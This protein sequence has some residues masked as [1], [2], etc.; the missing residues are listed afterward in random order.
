MR[1]YLEDGWIVTSVK[2]NIVQWSSLHAPLHSDVDGTLQV[3][4]PHMVLNVTPLRISGNRSLLQLAP[5]AFVLVFCRKE[6]AERKK[7]TFAIV[8]GPV[9]RRVG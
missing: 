7:K 4:L 3:V 5:S 6:V 1:R 9:G 2:A 8:A